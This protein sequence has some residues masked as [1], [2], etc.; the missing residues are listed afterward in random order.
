V[1]LILAFPASGMAATAL[2][3]MT[4]LPAWADEHS[5]L[6]VVL[7]SEGESAAWNAGGSPGAPDDM[8]YITAVMDAVNESYCIDQART[9]AVG[10]SDGGAM[11]QA[12]TCA[13]PERIAAVAL[14]ASTYGICRSGAPLVAFHGLHDAIVPYE[15]GP[16]PSDPSREFPS[17]RRSVTEWAREAG[18]D[19]LPVVSHP[20]TEVDL[21]TFKR[22][23]RGDGA[24]LLYTIIG[25]G[26]TW[27]GRAPLGEEFGFSTQ[28]LSATD[29]MWEF[30]QAFPRE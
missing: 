3:G 7:E 25:G 24:A 14:V 5:V 30:F 22:C 18:C 15:G 17:V 1:P 26:H 20:T 19:A 6:L 10:Y 4:G 27:P 8:R 13:M 29:T 11:S 23:K 9:F 2:A 12:V 28:Q 16:H 21:S